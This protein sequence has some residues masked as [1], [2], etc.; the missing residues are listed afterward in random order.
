MV[1]PN[2]ILESSMR[3]GRAFGMNIVVEGIEDQAD[4]DWVM[5]ADCNKVQGN[6][7]TGSLTAAEFISWEMH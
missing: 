3:V 5:S 2:A 1:K 6:Y 7:I 4:L